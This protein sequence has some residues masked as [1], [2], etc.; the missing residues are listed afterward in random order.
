MKI[1]KLWLHVYCI[2][3]K[4]NIVAATNLAFDPLITSN[5]LMT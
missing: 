5:K 1:F 3:N 2:S 4:K